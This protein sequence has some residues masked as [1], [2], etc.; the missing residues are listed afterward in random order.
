M[1]YTINNEIK[2]YFEVVGHGEPIIMHHGNGNCLKDWYTLGFVDKLSKD[3][4]LILIDSRGHGKSDKPHNPLSYSIKNRADD[5]ICVLNQLNIKKAHCFGASI[6]A[7][8]CMFLA[9]YYPNRFNSYIFATPYF[10][11]FNNDIKKALLKNPIAY[12]KEL[13]KSLGHKITNK[14]M[15]QTFLDN[16]AI[17]L[18]AANSSEWFDYLD[19]CK[20][21][22][23]PSLI[24]AGSKEKSVPYLLELSKNLPNNKIHIF[25]NL[26]HAQVY[27]SSK[28]VTPII[29][30]F[31]KNLTQ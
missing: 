26:N 27:W 19:Y 18:W 2:I 10:T 1:P 29:N 31:V 14:E 3:F 17:A 30:D 25:P 24:Y 23:S 12:V 9:K 22:K 21:I 11:Q 4:Q 8:T 20:Y 16:D 7:S 6:G 5:S 28:L 13:E 15:R